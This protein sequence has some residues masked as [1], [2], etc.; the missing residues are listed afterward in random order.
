MAVL[1]NRRSCSLVFAV[2]LVGCY[3]TRSSPS[4][5]PDASRSTASD[6]GPQRRSEA[7]ESSTA[8][9]AEPA[10]SSRVLPDPNL[11]VA[12]I[13]DQSIG[14]GAQEVLALIQREGAALVVHAGDLSYGLTTPTGWEAQ[15][16]AML[17]ADFPYL[18]AA[19]NHDMDDWEGPRGFS[20]ILRERL[21]R[22]PALK[23]WGSVGLDQQCRFRGIDLVLSAV[24]TTGDGHEA[25]LE[26]A[27]ARPG[28]LFRMCV[29]HKNQHD[30]Q[31][32]TK[33]DEVGY[34]AY[35]I[36]QRH[37]AAVITGHEHSYARTYTLTRLG[38]RALGHGAIGS[39][40]VVE[41]GLGKTFVV[42]SGL[43]GHSA[44]ALSPDH[45]G[46][47]WWASIYA[48]DFQLENGG[49]SGTLSLIE[50]GALFIDF[51]VDGNPQRARGYF[52][53]V[54]DEVVD[55]FEIQADFE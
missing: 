36:C 2:A 12:F 31:A 6:A 41:L 55:R 15:L 22:T 49:L 52:K 38:D 23:C 51:H 24:G 16:D 21:Q 7:E 30:L 54:R 19:G 26:R 45:A 25:Y 14:S 13:G 48:N 27:L 47:T 28:A 18:V 53:T 50:F 32:G 3:V 44:R 5:E 1:S 46:D 39:P 10:R 40:A 42:V 29:W 37:G 20:E 33:L 9:S 17:G 43:G 4:T 8:G 34:L 35:Q 11:R